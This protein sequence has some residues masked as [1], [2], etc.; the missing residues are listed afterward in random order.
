MNILG[1]LSS[2]VRRLSAQARALADQHPDFSTIDH[3]MRSMLHSDPG[4][5]V[6]NYQTAAQDFAQHPWV[7]KALRVWA[8]SV[9]PLPLRVRRADGTLDGAH[10]LIDLLEH[11]NE[12]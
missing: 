9:G 7:H 11:P 1:R 4:V 10:A 6:W 2:A 3:L 12:E 5:N 8:D